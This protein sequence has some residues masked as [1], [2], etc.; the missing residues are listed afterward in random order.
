MTNHE[1]GCYIKLICFCWKEGSIPSGIKSIA[2][3]LH[4]TEQEMAILWEA[5]APCFI[6]SEDA[7]RLLHPRLDAEREKQAAHKAKKSLAGKTGMD[8][9]WGNREP[10]PLPLFQQGPTVIVSQKP[11]APVKLTPVASIATH[12]PSPATAEPKAKKTKTSQHIDLPDGVSAGIYG[13]FLKLRTQKS[14]PFTLTALHGFISEAKIANIGLD[15][16]FALCCHKGWTGFQAAWYENLNRAQ[17]QNRSGYQVKG[18]IEDSMSTDEYR[19]YMLKELGVS[20]VECVD[21]NTDVRL[22][23]ELEGAIHD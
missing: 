16:V 20:E 22:G 15:E 4:E 12:T 6:P 8:K 5:I 11:A 17:Q 21:A 7:D 19:S 10:K 23:L 1:C 14:A 2:R 9:R 13:D 18:R 3:I